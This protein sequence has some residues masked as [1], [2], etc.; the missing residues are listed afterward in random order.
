MW[1][2]PSGW[3]PRE[4][5]LYDQGLGSRARWLLRIDGGD[6][7][8]DSRQEAPGGGWEPSPVILEV[9]GCGEALATSGQL[10]TQ[11]MRLAT[12]TQQRG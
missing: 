12:G 5:V 6:S 7:W 9:A 11:I 4:L 1:L 8:R 2:I 10:W 3:D